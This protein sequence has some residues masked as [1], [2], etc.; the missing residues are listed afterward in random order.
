V[1]RVRQL[2]SLVLAGTGVF[3]VFAGIRLR[4][5]GQYGPGPGFLAFWVGL[6][7][8][9]LSVVWFGQVS[10]EPAAAS[11]AA[12]ASGPGGLGRVA[13]IILAL[14]TFAVL[15]TPLG[16]KL[17]M[18]ALLLFLFF[19]FDREHVLAKLVVAVAGSKG[20]HYVFEHVLRVPLPYASLPVLRA[21]GF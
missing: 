14:V 10:L 15:L 5:G 2:S 3:L 1:K 13:A 11:P 4:L 7:L 21:L 16:F 20:T 19:A 18:L 12:A 17:V 9:I 6:P 8:A